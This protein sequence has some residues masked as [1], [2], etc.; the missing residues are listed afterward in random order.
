M[1]EFV[2]VW[3]CQ[4]THRWPS[5]KGSRG[6]WLVGITS[7]SQVFLVG[8]YL[9]FLCICT[10]AYVHI[11]AYDCLYIYIHA[12]D[13]L[14]IYI[15]VCDMYQYIHIWTCIP[16]HIHIH[17]YIHL[18]CFSSHATVSLRL[19]SVFALRFS[20]QYCSRVPFPPHHLFS[21]FLS[22]SPWCIILK[23]Q[24]QT[25]KPPGTQ[26]SLRN[27]DWYGASLAINK[28]NSTASRLI[29][30]EFYVSDAFWKPRRIVP[31]H[32][33]AFPTCSASVS[34]SKKM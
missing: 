8:V 34:P 29:S 12:Y 24:L 10:R 20:S 18:F 2:Y 7:T 3:K 11:H 6:E 9:I 15:H 14:Y 26:A 16:I 17:V 5:R 27:N 25:S 31:S 19:R 33:L 32:Q 28:L 30:H 4:V 23:Q 13:C 22:F 21:L 1:V